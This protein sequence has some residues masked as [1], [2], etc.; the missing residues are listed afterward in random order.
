MRY[1]KIDIQTKSRITFTFIILLLSLGNASG[2]KTDTTLIDSLTKTAYFNARLN[3]DNSILN[4][5]RALAASNKLLYKKG[6]ADSY[7]AL[8]ASYLAKYNPNDSAAHYYHLAL[9][10]YNNLNKFR[11]MALACYG[12]S[13]VY[14][15]KSDPI[16]AIKFGNL[17]IEYFEKS[18]SQQEIITAL[19]AL[20][21]LQKQE[22]NYNK[23]LEL[24]DK[25]IKI[26]HS[27]NDTFQW[28]NALNNKGNI[29]KDMFLFNRAIDSYF[30]AFDLWEITKDSSGLAIAYG[31]IANAYY[32]EGDYKKSLEFNFKKLSIINNTANLWEKIKTINN[33]A[34]SYNHLNM[35][36]SALYYMKK[37]LNISLKM[38]YPEGIANTYNN[39]ASAFWGLGETDS[40]LFYSSKA[41]AIAENINSSNLAKFKLTRAL[42]LDRQKKYL[43]ALNLAKDAYNLANQKKDNHI[44]SEASFLLS[45]VY[46]H[47]GKRELAYPFL[48]EHLKLK[49]SIS[50]MEYM[51]KVTRLDIQHE[52]ETKQRETQYEIDMLAKNNRISA[53]QLQK[54]RILLIALILL[55]FALVSI[56]T[57]LIRNKNHRIE[58]MNL[59][60]RNYLFQLEKRKAGSKDEDTV[61]ELAE[62][63]GLTHREKEIMELIATGIGNEEIAEKLF[64]S[65]NTIKFHIKNIFIKLDVKNRVQALQKMAG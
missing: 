2:N 50:N 51:R 10:A 26:A 15:F 24:S 33:V 47:L 37:S 5:H 52:Y 21:F 23:A 54:A 46:N 65:K 28:A 16:E 44:L 27:V 3:P 8:G 48:I 61:N 31:S 4:A 39:M 29:F 1:L 58:Q 32:F 43:P 13:Y 22:D 17:S 40:T 63:Y 7:L 38:N 35:A 14:S 6:A 56:S 55:S 41:I 62:N 12:L 45:E 49:D 34:L 11:G 36:D 25:A 9:E 19:E 59:E 20:I 64:V 60:I 18:G 53:A 57:L 30:K 42:A